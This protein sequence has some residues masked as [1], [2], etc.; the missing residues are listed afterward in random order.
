[1]RRVGTD[2]L[3]YEPEQVCGLD[4]A[5][6]ELFAGVVSAVVHHDSTGGQD[7]SEIVGLG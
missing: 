2:L 5:L 7:G 3:G 1:M 4:Q 6:V